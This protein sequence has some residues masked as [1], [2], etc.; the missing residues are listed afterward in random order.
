MNSSGNTP[1]PMVLPHKD[2]GSFVHAL[3]RSPPGL[4][5]LGVG[6]MLSW[7]EYTALWSRILGVEATYYEVPTTDLAKELPEG[8]ERELPEMALYM[9]EFGYDGGDP[10]IIHPTG[11]PVDCPTTSIEDYIKNEDWSPILKS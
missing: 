11:L 10:S 2:T 5:L 7:R 1:I 6:Q 8:L 4:T 3:V 9:E